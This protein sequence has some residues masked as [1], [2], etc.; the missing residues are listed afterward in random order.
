MK[1]LKEYKNLDLSDYDQDWEESP[2][3]NDFDDA[4]DIIK[5]YMEENVIMG[6]KVPINNWEDF[7]NFCTKYDI[8]WASKR[9]VGYDDKTIKGKEFI[10]VTLHPFKTNKDRLKLKFFSSIKR[11]K[12]NHGTQDIYVFDNKKIKLYQEL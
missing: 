6:I 10:V 1:Y 11:F 7:T 3:D 5:K 4:M 8:I 2:D 9:P 12:K